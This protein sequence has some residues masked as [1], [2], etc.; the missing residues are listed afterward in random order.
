MNRTG[1]FATP[2]EIERLRRLLDQPYI[3]GAGGKTPRSPRVEA[4]RLALKHG[5]PETGGYYGCDL[6]TGEFVSA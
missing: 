5:L 4:H 2:E 3:V 1:V 6:E